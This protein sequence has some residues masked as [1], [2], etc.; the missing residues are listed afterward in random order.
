MTNMVTKVLTTRRHTTSAALVIGTAPLTTG[1]GGILSGQQVWDDNTSKLYIGVGDDGSG[2]CTS[3]ACIAGAG[4]F[5]T[6]SQLAALMGAANGIAT[7]DST[8]KIPA[9]QMTAAVTGAMIYQ[10]AWNASTNSPA[11]SSGTGTKGYFYKVSVAG[12][13][14]V[15]GNAT[16]NI[17]DVIAFDG[18][19]WDKFDGPEEAVT[20]VAGRIGAVILT[21]AD[22]TDAGTMGKALLQAT[23]AAAAKA[24]L[25]ITAGDVSGLAAAAAAAA[26]VQTVAGRSGT[27]TLT[28]SDITDW[29][30][31][32]NAALAAFAPTAVDGG[33]I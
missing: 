18:V 15:D 4:G 23:T 22:L 31:T 2:N 32:L 21:S 8:G 27:V 5:L 7:L 17:G 3:I 9:S 1:A 29:S 11:L 19:T 24:A 12:A 26:P 33:A 25:A 20:T 14:T 16:W 6:L 28:H 13:S 10:G 30:S